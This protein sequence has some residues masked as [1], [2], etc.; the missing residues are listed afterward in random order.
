[1]SVSEKAVAEAIDKLR[2]AADVLETWGTTAA[3]TAQNLALRAAE[4]LDE[5]GTG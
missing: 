2:A 1:M 3:P 4:I 5:R